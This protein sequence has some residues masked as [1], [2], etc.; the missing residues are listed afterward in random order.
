[1]TVERGGVHRRW[2]G[3]ERH[4]DADRRAARGERARAG[5]AALPVGPA[6]LVEMH[7][8]VDHAGQEVETAGVDLLARAPPRA[9]ARARRCA[10]RGR[11]HPS[12][13]TPPAV[14]AVAPRTMRSKSLTRGARAGRG[15]AR[16][17]DGRRYILQRDRLGRVVADPAGAADEQH[18]HGGDRRQH[19]GVVAG[20]ARQ[21]LDVVP[22][23]R[24]RLGEQSL[25]SGSHATADVSCTTLK[26]ATTFRAAPIAVANSRRRSR[27]AS[28]TASSPWRRS[29]ES[30][31]RPGITLDAPGSAASSP[32]VATRPGSAR[33][34]A[35]TASD[36]LGGGTERIAAQAPSGRCPRGR[37]HPRT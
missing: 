8:R 22:G 3:V 30:T 33:A 20:A 9:P 35:S 25:S 23:A 7:V 19:R 36:Q 2:V 12:R 28:R 1:M 10:R 11:R 15:T 26:S 4:L 18:R 14:T 6:G 16:H 29:S 37:R 32:T 17:I 13:R 5:A 31:A 21:A 34:S 27:A 24:D